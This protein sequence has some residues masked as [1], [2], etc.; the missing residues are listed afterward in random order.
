[1]P[2]RVDA[3][4]KII[5]ETLRNLGCLVWITSDLGKGAPDLVVGIGNKHLKLIEIKDGSKP[6]SQRKLTLDEQRFHNNWKD[7][8]KV[9][10]SIDEAIEFVNALRI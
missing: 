1:M 3:N 8:I 10:S 6:P 9:I 7:H 5:V 2:K 4:Q